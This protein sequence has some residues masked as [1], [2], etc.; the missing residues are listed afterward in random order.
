MERC[1]PTRFPFLRCGRASTRGHRNT[2]VTAMIP[3]PRNTSPFRAPPDRCSRP[4]SEFKRIPPSYRPHLP[5]STPPGTPTINAPVRMP[6]YAGP[7]PRRDLPLSLRP[8]LRGEHSAH[9]GR[10]DAPTASPPG[11]WRRSRPAAQAPPIRLSGWA[12]WVH[13][14]RPD[15]SVGP[16]ALAR[17]GRPVRAKLAPQTAT[18]LGERGLL[19]RHRLG[20]A[21]PRS[22]A[23]WG[24]WVASP[25]SLCRWR[26]TE[27]GRLPRLHS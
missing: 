14:K 17:Q 1:R 3:S 4:R 19:A 23:A 20:P 9:K 24:A 27:S 22:G 11:S 18:A 12:H 7:I 16:A 8:V 5:S 13:P 6:L 26:R 10:G 21:H 2:A 25:A 15:V